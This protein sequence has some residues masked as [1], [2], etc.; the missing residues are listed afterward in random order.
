[1][2]IDIAALQPH[3]LALLLDRDEDT[4]ISLAA[5]IAVEG[6]RNEV[7][8]LGNQ[9][10]DGNRRREAY[11]MATA[12]GAK[13]PGG[14]RWRMFNPKTDGDVWDFILC[15]AIHH[16][17]RPKG[18]AVT[19]LLREDLKRNYR[20][21][22]RSIGLRVGCHT[23]FVR[24]ERLA[25]EEANLIPRLAERIDAQGHTRP[26]QDMG[27]KPP[28]AAGDAWEQPEE[29]SEDAKADAEVKA[30]GKEVFDHLGNVLPKHL[31]DVFNNAFY[32]D[33]VTS[34]RWMAR[35]VASDPRQYVRLHVKP[36][37]KPVVKMLE[38][39][40]DAMEVLLPHHEH[41]CLCPHC[42]GKEGGCEQCFC[43]GWFSKGQFEEA[44]A[45]E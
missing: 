43:T 11:R 19:P 2:D 42:G 20:R 18:R 14:F 3:P 41:F 31:R 28:P 21:S 37:D 38:E 17:D 4:L 33:A 45:H 13:P 16:R 12:Q 40:A 27:R 23:K 39:I 24:V 34:L 5:S 6:M 22:D 10:V 15:R 8:V 25:M 9:I 32:E 44:K 26:A 7:V 35:H 30:A 36:A 1:M 29:G